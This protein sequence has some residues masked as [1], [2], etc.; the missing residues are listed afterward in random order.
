M[1]K[2]FGLRLIQQRTLSIQYTIQGIALSE[3]SRGNKNQKVSS[4]LP[5]T[6]TGTS[7]D[8]ITHNRGDLSKIFQRSYQERAFS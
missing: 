8:I 3:L 2:E 1:L 4:N 7:S 5:L 6:K